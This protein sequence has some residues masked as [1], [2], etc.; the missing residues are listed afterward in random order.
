M[1][2]KKKA[3]KKKTPV[4]KTPLIELDPSIDLDPLKLPKPWTPRQYKFALALLSDP[5]RNAGAAARAAGFAD[6]SAD[7]HAH[8]MISEDKYSHV[9]NYIRHREQV[10]LSK[11]GYDHDK[12][13]EGLVKQAGYNIFDFYTVDEKTGDLKI[14]WRNVPREMGELVDAIETKQL[15]IKVVQGG[16]EISLPVL[17]AFVRFSDRS[18]AKDMLNKMYGNYERD[19]TRRHVHEG[20]NAPVKF[21]E[22]TMEEA[23]RAYQES[24]KDT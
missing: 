7:V 5:Q 19:N 17:S 16:E 9:V 10:V 4:H 14:D 3:A 2:T 1:V 11:Y 24:L 18:K 15:A 23:A 12:H 21:T 22:M 20:G 8:R 13:V 6:S